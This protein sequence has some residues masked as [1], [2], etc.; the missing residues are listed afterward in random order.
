MNKFPK[1][2]LIFLSFMCAV[3]AAAQNGAVIDRGEAEI[4][5]F[6]WDGDMV[7]SVYA[8]D[9]GFWC[10]GEPSTE[11][12]EYMVVIRPDGSLKIKEGGN[13]FTRVFHYRQRFFCHTSESAE[14]VGL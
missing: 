14:Q 5:L 2:T 6:E 4:G 3:T 12:Y 11:P 13:V 9:I 10:E 1:F 7:I 8:T